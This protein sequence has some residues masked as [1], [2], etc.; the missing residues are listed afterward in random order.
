MTWPYLIDE[1]EAKPLSEAAM[2]ARDLEATYGPYEQG[3]WPEIG[4]GCGFKAWSGGGSQVVEIEMPNGDWEA[5]RAARL[6]HCIADAL[7]GKVYEAF[8][9]VTSCLSPQQIYDMLPMRFPMT[10]LVQV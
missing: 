2:W 10:H 9:K 4:C 6:P 7:K 1:A 8:K 3:R 5:I